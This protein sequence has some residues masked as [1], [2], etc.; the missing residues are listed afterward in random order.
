MWLSHCRPHPELVE[1]H[2]AGPTRYLSRIPRAHPLRQLIQI[3]RLLAALEK[4]GMGGALFG[5]CGSHFD[6][7]RVRQRDAEIEGE[8][9]AEFFGTSHDA[10]LGFPVAVTN[11]ELIVEKGVAE[12]R[13]GAGGD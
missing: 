6:N 4:I 7:G 5:D 8:N 12:M 1:R 11:G 3:G 9:L 10:P 13:A 2:I